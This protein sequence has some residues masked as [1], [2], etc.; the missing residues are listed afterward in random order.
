MPHIKTVN[1]SSDST[2]QGSPGPHNFNVEVLAKISFSEVEKKIGLNY[3][4]T[5]ALYEIDDAMDVYSVFPNNHQLFLQRASRGD[6]DDFLGFSDTKS[7]N[8]QSGAETIRHK[9]SV[10]A[11]FEADQKMELKALVICVPETATAMKWSSTKQVQ[12]VHG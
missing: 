8:A 12:V 4:V 1:I 9:F 2:I 6:K 3:N 10:R 7:V 11:S 5:I